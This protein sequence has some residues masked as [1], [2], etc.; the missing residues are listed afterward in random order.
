MI[1][2][3]T[4]FEQLDVAA[5]LAAQPLPGRVARR[6]RQQRSR[7]RALLRGRAARRPDWTLRSPWTSARPPTAA[8]F[9]AALEAAAGGADALIAVFVPALGT[10]A[11]DVA[12]VLGDAATGETTLMGAFMAQ[13][14]AELAA[15]GRGGAV[16]LYRSPVEAARA[17]GRVAATRAGA[18]APRVARRSSATSTPTAPRPC[19]RRR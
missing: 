1:R 18:G 2:T 9:A 12:R 19:S 14:E 11:A 10:S 6:H 8:E 4:V 16:P 15:L 7:T 5:L 13:G 3:D 17:L